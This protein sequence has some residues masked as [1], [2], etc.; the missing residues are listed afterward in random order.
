MIINCL[1][2]GASGD[3]VITSAATHQLAKEGTVVFYT[4]CQEIAR[5]CQG[6]SYAIDSDYWDIRQAGR[7]II[8]NMYP[9]NEG[10]PDTPPARHIIDYCCSLAGLP[11][12]LPKVKSFKRILDGEYITLQREALWSKYKEYGLWDEVVKE[13]KL[14]VIEL[15][16]DR[17]WCDSFALVQHA[18]LHLGIDS[19]FNHVAAAYDTPAVILWGSTLPSFSGYDSAINLYKNPECGPCFKERKD[20]SVHYRGTC[21]DPCIDK[22]TPAEVLTAIKELL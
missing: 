4:K 3:V 11:P 18:R 5:L 13:L 9:T 17:P 19:V 8:F 14:P 10:Y 22:V 6:V 20:W 2:P 15:T 7:D 16:P 1:R 21:D 12:S